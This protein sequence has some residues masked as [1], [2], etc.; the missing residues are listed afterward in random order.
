MTYKSYNLYTI[1]AEKIETIL[2]RNISNSRG[3]DFYDTFILLSLNRNIISRDELLRAIT[4]KASE[5]NSLSY[6][7]NY[8]KLI[9]DISNSSKIANIWTNYV[10]N[11]S[12]ADGISISDSLSEIAWV[13]ESFR[14]EII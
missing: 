6:I 14:N 13:F 12:Y 11:Y 7:K 8:Q 9:N 2:S 4:T 3:R 5:R 10:K 1:L